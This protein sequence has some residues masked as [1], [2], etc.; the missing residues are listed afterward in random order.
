MVSTKSGGRAILS[1][2]Q[3]QI[4]VLHSQEQII[5]QRHTLQKQQDDIVNDDDDDDA[6]DDTANDDAAHDD[7]DNERVNNNNNNQQQFQ[8]L[9]TPTL[10]F[11]TA[12]WCGPCRL[13][14]PVVKEIIKQFVPKIDVVQV[15]TDDLPDIA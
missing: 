11:F 12:P 13:S 15:C 5:E 7:H 9:Q 6:N 2:L 4:E 14:N 10:V 3:F 8:P 1:E